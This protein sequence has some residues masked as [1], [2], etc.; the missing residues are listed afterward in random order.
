MVYDAAATY[1]GKCLNDAIIAGPALQPSLADVITRFRAHEVSW[2]SDVEAMFSR[3]WLAEEDANYFCFL[4]PRTKGA[5]PDVC[6]MNR[7]SFVA[8]CSPFVAIYTLRI[9]ED[10]GVCE[11]VAAAVR[12]SWS[13]SL[14]VTYF[15][16]GMKFVNQE[17]TC[18]ILVG[19]S[20]PL[21]L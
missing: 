2:A 6:R 15:S 5:E 7:L 12:D 20:S 9:M 18:S 1:R 16:I 4:W 8:S 21:G 10:A 11:E 19:T 14:V 3:F 17:F 13:S